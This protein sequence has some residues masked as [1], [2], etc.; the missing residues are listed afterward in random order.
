VSERY[1]VISAAILAGGVRAPLR[2]PLRKISA[3]DSK[4]NCMNYL[5][6]EGR[7]SRLRFAQYTFVSG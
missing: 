5:R 7:R 1:L 2:G 4:A 6:E 3:I